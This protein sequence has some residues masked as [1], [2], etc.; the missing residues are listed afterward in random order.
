MVCEQND[1]LMQQGAVLVDDTDDGNTI[2]VLFLLEHSVQDGR[3]TNSG[4]PNVISQKLQFTAI[5]PSGQVSNAGIAPHLNLRPAARHEI[6]AVEDRLNEDWLC[7][8]LEKTV[9]QFATVTLAQAHVAEV[10]NRRG[11]EIDKV[12]QE[13]KA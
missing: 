4:N 1:H 2:S 12:E 7:S 6:E 13:V 11:P 10:R 8:N 3:P 5:N 9:M